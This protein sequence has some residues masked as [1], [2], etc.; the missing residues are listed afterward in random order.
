MIT[1]MNGASGHTHAPRTHIDHQNQARHT[2]RSSARHQTPGRGH[3]PWPPRSRP[4]RAALGRRRDQAQAAACGTD[5]AS[6]PAPA[7]HPRP[8]HQ[9]S[10]I[11]SG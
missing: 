6:M 10:K 11:N 9:A 7:S 8:A 4:P 1:A 3:H 5:P 2:A